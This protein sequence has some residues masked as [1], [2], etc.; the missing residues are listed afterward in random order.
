M[1]TKAQ[2][3]RSREVRRQHCRHQ[4]VPMCRVFGG[5]LRRPMLV[6]VWHAQLLQRSTGCTIE[7]EVP[8]GI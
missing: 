3:L 1:T 4:P 5:K 6:S 8:D 7:G 2:R